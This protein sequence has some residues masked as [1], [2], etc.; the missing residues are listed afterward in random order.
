M[1]SAQEFRL[2]VFLLDLRST[3]FG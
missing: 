1:D 2:N 3:Y